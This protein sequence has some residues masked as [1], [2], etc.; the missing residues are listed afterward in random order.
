MKQTRAKKPL[1]LK[2]DEAYL[3]NLKRG[4]KAKIAVLKKIGVS[5]PN[6]IRN[7]IDEL[8]KLHVGEAE[9]A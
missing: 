2:T 1:E 9:Q 6:H 3:T 4:Q 5:V 7:Q 8:F